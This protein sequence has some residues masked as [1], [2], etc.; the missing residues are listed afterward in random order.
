MCD[1]QVPPAGTG[2]YYSRAQISTVEFHFSRGLPLLDSSG[3]HCEGVSGASHV[4]EKHQ[5]QDT[6]HKRDGD[7]LSRDHHRAVRRSALVDH[8][9]RCP[10]WNL[11]FS[12]T[13][14]SPLEVWFL[15]ESN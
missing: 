12:S 6:R 7:G 9:G 13:S 2:W 15:Q 11:D 1:P 4:V 5:A 10:R 8:P 3:P 14:V